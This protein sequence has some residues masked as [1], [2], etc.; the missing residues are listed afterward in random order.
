MSRR[1]NPL[2][3]TA[4]L[5]ASTPAIAA[6]F[7]LGTPVVRGPE[8]VADWFDA[9]KAHLETQK[10]LKDRTGRAKNIILFVGDG[11]GISTVTA[12]RILAGEKAGLVGPERGSLHFETFP[13]VALSKVYQ[14]DQQTPDSAPTATAAAYESRSA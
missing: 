5:L 14:W 11:M 10:Q 3:V 4:T 12:A 13:N 7:P 2:L 6:D 1:F 8:S 9:G